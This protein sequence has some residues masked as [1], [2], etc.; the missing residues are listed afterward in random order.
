MF[1]SDYFGIAREVVEGYGAFDISLTNDLPLFIDPF[2]LFNSENPNYKTL[3]DAMIEYLRFLRDM[4]AASD[5][6]ASLVSSWYQFPEIKQTWLGFTGI[7]NSGRGLGARFASA[8]AR[9]LHYVFQDFGTEGVTQG[10][11]LEK[12]CLIES[13]VGRDNISDFTT[14]LIKRHL[15]EFTHT[16]TLLHVAPDDQDRYSVPKVSFNYGTRTWGPAVYS[17]PR[18]ENDYVI[19]TPM[20]IL[21][22]D[23]TWISRSDMISQFRDVAESMAN[24]QLRAHLNEYLARVLPETP[25]PKEYREAVARAVL[26]Y[27]EFIDYYI[28]TKEEKAEEAS[29]EAQERTELVRRVF[30]ENASR[31]SRLVA[32]DLHEAVKPASS[33]GEALERV[34]YLK[35]VIEDNDGYR[36]FYVGNTPMRREKDLQTLFRLTW[37]KTMY[38]LNSEVN[39]G[40]G[41]VDYKISYG[42]ADKSLVEF[43]LASNPKLR[44]NLENQVA[45]YKTA[46]AT[47]K[48][49]KVILYF[50]KEDLDRVSQIIQEID[51]EDE[52]AIVLIDARRDNKPSASNV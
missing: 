42:F 34:H 39:N 15:L 45:V 52:E 38:D 17:L 8:L 41:P 12:L 50:T 21:T 13:G 7:G 30:V 22:K 6:P 24:D 46:N 19:L 43:K 10:T 25:K 3:H 40:R 27:P 28:Q 26:R 29:S 2:L 23:D 32:Q 11:H 20:D 9:N 33:Y 36:V 51:V 48:A 1:F 31:L 18:F 14:N 44:Q 49:I 16:F 4:A 37:F 47:K 35:H 5:L